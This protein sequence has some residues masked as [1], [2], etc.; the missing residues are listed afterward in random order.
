MEYEQ[1][2]ND[3]ATY[4]EQLYKTIASNL[5]SKGIKSFGERNLYLCKDF[6]L[7]YPGILQTLSA[8]S[9]LSESSSL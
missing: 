1:K 4:D 5:K 3:R 2:G 8:K 7:A 6:Y 9:F